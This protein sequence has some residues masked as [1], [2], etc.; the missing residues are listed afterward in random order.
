MKPE[1]INKKER[2]INEMSK[3][4]NDI[5]QHSDMDFIYQANADTRKAIDKL[6]VKKTDRNKQVVIYA[7]V[8]LIVGMVAGLYI[9]SNMVSIASRSQVVELKVVGSEQLKAQAQSPNQ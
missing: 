5:V 7:L 8:A 9:S 1:L 6:Y 4:N 2:V 3:K